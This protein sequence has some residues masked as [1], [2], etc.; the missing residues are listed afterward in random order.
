MTVTQHW[1]FRS[2]PAELSDTSRWRQVDMS[3]LDGS[4]RDRYVQMKAALEAYISTGRI[5]AISAES[6]IAGVEIIRQLNRC[7][8]ANKDGGLV[9]WPALI[10][11]QRIKDYVRRSS[12]PNSTNGEG[13]GFS[14]AFKA[15]LTEHADI[16]EKI[17]SLIFKRKGMVHEAKISIRS[18]HKVFVQLCEA[19]G[20]TKDQYPF[21]SKSYGRRSLSRYVNQ[22][23]EEHLVEGTAARFGKDATKKLSVGTGHDAHIYST[24]PYDLVGVDAHKLHCFGTIR[25]NGPRGPQ[26]I[27]VQRLWIVPVLEAQCRAILGYSVGIRTECS[28]AIIEAALQSALST[29]SPREIEVPGM[30]YRPGAGLPSGIFPELAGR[31]WVS[32]MF[33]NAAAHFANS[34]AQRARRRIG[35]FLNYGPVGHWEHRAALERLMKTLEIYGFQRLPSSTGSSPND[36]IRDEPVRQAVN[37]G[38][39]WETLVDLID[40]TIA[41]YNVTPNEALG[42][43]TPLS[44]LRDHLHT[45]AP[46]FLPRRL[47]PA[48]G[49]QPD[50]GITVETRFIRGNREQGRR[51]YIEIDRVHYSNIVLA[52]AMA[53]IGEKLRIHI[54]E[55]DMCTVTAYLESGEEL[56]VLTAQGGWGRTRHTR[57]MRKQINALRDSGDLIVLSGDDPVQKLMSFYASEAHRQAEKNVYKVSRAATKLVNAAY[58]S[59]ESVSEKKVADAVAAPPTPELPRSKP[60][61]L[62][63]PPVWKTIV[64]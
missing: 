25:I 64:S 45:E 38:I 19:A 12:L 44:V 37:T 49:L 3:A 60:T 30:T 46:A 48:N 1:T 4:V 61:R 9:G 26:R 33:D 23:I 41:N 18:L 32:L 53:L 20:I 39:D 14:G 27:A 17:D 52:N 7:L 43:R 29:W 35:C 55:S 34:I 21:N 28:S 36:P 51:P 22:V 8:A 40:I 11:G 16:Q 62:I 2:L 5:R 15:F 54:R 56:G 50:F 10:Q 63:K 24:A 57:E 58:V 59:G 6:G 13:A 47:P 42:N 31:G